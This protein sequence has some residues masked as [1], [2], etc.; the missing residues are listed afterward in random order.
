MFLVYPVTES[1]RSQE[2][3]LGCG[4]KSEYDSHYV[5]VHR[6]GKFA[7][8]APFDT[9]E[10]TCT[11]DGDE[12]VIRDSN[13][14]LPR[15]I[16]FFQRSKTKPS[17][18]SIHEH[19]HQLDEEYRNASTI[20]MWISDD[21]DLTSRWKPWLDT[22][23]PQ[24][25]G[26]IIKFFLGLEPFLHYMTNL[27]KTKVWDQILPKIKVIICANASTHELDLI[28]NTF[29]HQIIDSSQIWIYLGSTASQL[30]FDKD[31]NTKTHL[32]VIKQYKK[33][34]KSKFTFCS[35]EVTLMT[36][37][38]PPATSA[39]HPFCVN[40]CLDPNMKPGKLQH[41]SISILRF[42]I[43]LVLSNPL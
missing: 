43:P 4:L 32:Q 36:H 34:K 15:Y 9:S 29:T 31:A 22:S 40:F 13:Q 6:K 35:N 33:A 5:L 17:T 14:S 26:N 25:H 27:R 38:I 16:I 1:V 21:Y 8:V 30:T 39:L 3:L 24:F 7:D 2:A 41:L 10:Q 20:T 37:C 19:S 42:I 12:I 23:F 28:F 18:D 11:A